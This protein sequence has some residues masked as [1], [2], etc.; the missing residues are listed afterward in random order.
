M[1]MVLCWKVTTCNNESVR[2]SHRLK[3]GRF[4]R[5]CGRDFYSYDWQVVPSGIFVFKRLRDA[6]RYGY[7]VSRKPWLHIWVCVAGA[8]LPFHGA[9]C[10]GI[11]VWS[12]P[13]PKVIELIMKEK[14]CY[15]NCCEGC[16]TVVSVIPVVRL[17]L[18][19]VYVRWRCWR[20][21]LETRIE[22]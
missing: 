21:R 5:T 11:V 18:A 9:T 7:A 22:R 16:Q 4:R 6:I 8:A 12:K 3:Y 10:G 13:H 15:V 2:P 14:Y 20:K 19:E 1:K 17:F